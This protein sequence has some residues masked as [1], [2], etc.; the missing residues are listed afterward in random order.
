VLADPRSFVLPDGRLD[1]RLVLGEFAAWWRQ[2]GEFL[3]KGEVYHEVAPQLIFM[4]FLTRIVDGGGFVDCDPLKDG[5]AQLDGY[6]ARL[7]LETG[8]LLIFDRRPAAVEQPPDPGFTN[9]HT[10]AGRTITL[11]RA[12]PAPAR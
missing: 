2:Y 5:L 10:P 3:V 11:L 8:T 7:G 12:W 1:F 6:L 4:A 9:E